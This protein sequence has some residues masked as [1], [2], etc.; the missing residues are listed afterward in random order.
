MLMGDP[1]LLKPWQYHAAP[2]NSPERGHRTPSPRS[3][4]EASAH[5]SPRG[6]RFGGGVD[7]AQKKGGVLG[8]IAAAKARQMHPMQVAKE[9]RIVPEPPQTPPTV[10]RAS[11]SFCA[12]CYTTS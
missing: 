10:H 4:Q 11:P 1:D 2:P 3:S 9:S 6:A 12:P 5:V 8:L 7:A